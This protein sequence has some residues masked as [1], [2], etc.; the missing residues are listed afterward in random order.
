MSGAA[1]SRRGL[2]WLLAL[3]LMNGAALSVATPDGSKVLFTSNWNLDGDGGDTL[4]YVIEMVSAPA[5]A[6]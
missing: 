5:D 2:I 1:S 6:S 4:D 3:I